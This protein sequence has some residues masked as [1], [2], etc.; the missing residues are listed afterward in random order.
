MF[1]VECNSRLN[2]TKTTLL[3]VMLFAITFIV[4]YIKNGLFYWT[5]DVLMRLIIFSQM[6]DCGG[7]PQVVQVSVCF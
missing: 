5:K 1:Q 4:H 7:L 2:P 6:A 3:K